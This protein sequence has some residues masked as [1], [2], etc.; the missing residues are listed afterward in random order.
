MRK[1]KDKPDIVFIILAALEIMAIISLV[2]SIILAIFGFFTVGKIMAAISLAVHVIT[3][4]EMNH[5]LYQ[6]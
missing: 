3:V 4:M 1:N 2:L 5:H 6:N